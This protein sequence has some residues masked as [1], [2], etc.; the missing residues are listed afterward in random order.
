VNVFRRQVD[1]AAHGRDVKRPAIG[2]ADPP[3]I[4]W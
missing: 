1:V 4:A 3:G 2:P